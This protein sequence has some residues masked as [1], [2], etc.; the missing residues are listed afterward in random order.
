MDI[1]KTVP[2]LLL[3]TVF[4]VGLQTIEPINA[5][6]N[7]Y[8]DFKV[9]NKKINY[10][11]AYGDTKNEFHLT[12]VCEKANKNK[13]YYEKSYLLKKTKKNQIKAYSV[14]YDKND[15]QKNTLLKTYKTTKS[16]KSFYTSMYKATA[17]KQVKSEA[18]KFFK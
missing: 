5:G 12:F 6:E 1:K 10:F 15:K 17:I 8:G 9:G 7:E 3:I 16:V 18:T 4:V 11:A 13:K 2:V 14:T